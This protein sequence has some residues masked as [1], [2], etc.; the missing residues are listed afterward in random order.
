MIPWGK[1]L[2]SLNYSFKGDGFVGV[3][4]EWKGKTYNFVNIYA[5]CNNMKR[6][7]L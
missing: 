6:R 3:N 1:Y 4:V 7:N 5:P 2:L